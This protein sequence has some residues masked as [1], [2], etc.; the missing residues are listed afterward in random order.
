MTNYAEVFE[1]L[2]SLT[3]IPLSIV[4]VQCHLLGSWPASPEGFYGEKAIG[5]VLTDF[6][7]QGRDADHP[8]ISYIEPGYFLGVMELDPERY[9]IIGLVSPFPHTRQEVLPMC[10]HVIK[11]AGVQT[12]CDLM[13]QNPSFSLTQVKDC[14]CLLVRLTQ[15]KVLPNENILFNDFSFDSNENAHKLDKE[16]FEQREEV[17][18]HVPT[19]YESVLCH[20]I[21]AG[22]RKALLKRFY[23]PVQGRV[24]KMSASPLRQERYALVCLATLVTRAAI[25]G[26]L[27]PETAF[28]LSDVYCQRADVLTDIPALQKMSYTMLTD[29]CDRVAQARGVEARS[30]MIQKCVDYISVHLHETIR[31]DDLSSHCGL[32]GRSLSLRFKKEVGMGITEY[33]HREKVREAQYLLRHSDFNLADITSYLAYPSQSYFTKIFKKYCGKTP[34][35]YREAIN[36]E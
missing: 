27:P 1:Q 17:D 20:A 35:Q 30:V 14:I 10:A 16:M 8:L 31:L 2:H 11:P 28:S 36:V 19:D 33:I 21:E 15:G 7:F 25:R 18:F 6:R 4:D 13:M 26:G 3:H 22:D 12:F 32:C 24:G 9:A 23:T 29:F 5:V 34:Q